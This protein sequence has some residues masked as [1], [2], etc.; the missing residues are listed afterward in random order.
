MGRLTW[1]HSTHRLTQL[2]FLG[3][4]RLYGYTHVHEYAVKMWLIIVPHLISSPMSTN[5]RRRSS[6]R[7]LPNLLAPAALR[8]L[9]DLHLY[10]SMTRLC[11]K[12]FLATTTSWTYNAAPTKTTT[13]SS[14]DRQPTCGHHHLSHRQHHIHRQCGRHRQNTAS[15]PVPHRPAWCHPHLGGTGDQCRAAAAA[16]AAAALSG[17]TVDWDPRQRHSHQHL[18]PSSASSSR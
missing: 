8:L 7:H 15:G 6:P 9:P 5:S 2:T 18:P 11:V 14:D 13:F 16:A 17:G 4:I 12:T 10:S 3:V 1:L